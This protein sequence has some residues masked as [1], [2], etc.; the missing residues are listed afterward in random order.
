MPNI[1]TTTVWCVMYQDVDYQID[2]YS[3]PQLHSIHLKRKGA[4]A[5]A[6]NQRRPI[7]RGALQTKIFTSN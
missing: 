1:T 6:K 3:P 4:D 2:G 5:E 7:H